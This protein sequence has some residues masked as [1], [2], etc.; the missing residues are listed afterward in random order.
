MINILWQEVS[1]K[2]DE[3]SA[4]AV[5]EILVECGAGGVVIEDPQMIRAR[6]AENIWDA[7]AFPEELLKR[8]YIRIAAY[9][10][11]DTD[12][13]ERLARLRKNLQDICAQD[14]PDSPMEITLSEVRE[15]DWA[16]SWKAYYKPVRVGNRIVI[17]PTWEEYVSR[18]GDI[19]IELDPGMAFGTG[20]H[21]T[22]VMCL[23]ALEGLINGGET[24]FDIGTGSG[25]LAIAA[26]KL[27]ASTVKAVDIDIVAVNS[28][29]ANVELNGVDDCV[30]VLAGNLL[31]KVSGQAD[32][33][34]A[35]IVADVIKLVC[36]DAV[37]AVR[38][39]GKFVASGIIAHREQDVI[40]T[41][42]EAGLVIKEVFRE[43]EWL[44]LVA[45]KE[46]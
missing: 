24:V 21:P 46:D 43:G 2:T 20:T 7:Y 17:K 25:I 31:D 12:T 41:I 35:N 19:V 27:G 5:A 23:R 32:L 4:D 44:S 11:V 42:K 14:F 40:E 38:S 16:N 39:G 9:F 18:E 3:K 36:P 28:A 15:E 26:A 29:L 6:I 8:D 45:L 1:V 33:V 10:P 37:K 13:D 22:T 30:E 34:I